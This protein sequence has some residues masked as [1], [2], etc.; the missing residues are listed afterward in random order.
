LAEAGPCAER[1]AKGHMEELSRYRMDFVWEPISTDEAARTVTYRLVPNP[2]RYDW[3]EDNGEKCLYD[4]LDQTLIPMA[5]LES[6]ISQMKGHPVTFQPP[7]IQDAAKYVSTRQPKIEA[8]LRGDFPAPAFADPSDDFLEAYSDEKGDFV[9][10]SLDIVGSTSHA[11]TMKPSEYVLLTKVMLY[12]LSDVVPLFHGYILK[13]TGDG[14]I[15][16]FPAPSFITKNDLAMDCAATLQR[17]ADDGLASA[18]A[19]MGYPAL[20]IRVGLDSGSAAVVVLGSPAAKEK[21]DIIGATVSLACKIQSLARPGGIALGEITLRNLHTKW[22]LRCSPLAT[23][24]DWKYRDPTTGKP[25]AVHE[26]GT[27]DP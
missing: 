6:M 20:R 5:V 27:P 23:G 26:Y 21:K 9:I 25:Y 16:F 3:V 10:L 2:E 15:A 17:L 11:T 14:F 13:Y 7:Q 8:M 22:R 24:I 4:K 18:F 19:S 12:E 1:R